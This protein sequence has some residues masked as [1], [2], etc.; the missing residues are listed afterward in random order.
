MKC[1][2]FLLFFL[3]FAKCACFRILGLNPFDGKSHFVMFER[4]YMELARR[5]HE[6]DVLSHFPREKPVP[7][8]TDISLKGSLPN[9]VGNFSFEL[10]KDT[11]TT[12]MMN[13]IT[14]MCGT[15]ICENAFKH[16]LTLKLKNT[17][18]KYDLIITEI[19]GTDCMFGFAHHF[20]VPVV[21][22]TTSVNQPWGNSRFGNPEEPTYIPSYFLPYTTNMSLV[23]KFWNIWNSFYTKIYYYKK[24]IEPSDY[25]VK[26]FFGED[27]PHLTELISRYSSL[28]MVNS[29][30]SINPARPWVPNVIEV[31]GLH[32][33]DPRPLTDSYK[34]VM[35]L[36]DKYKGVVYMSFGSL[37]MLQT[38]PLDGLKVL[39]S[40]FSLLSDYK[41]LVKGDKSKIP[42]SVIISPNVI[43]KSWTPQIDI[44]CHP[45]VVLFISHAGLMGTQESVFCGVPI[46]EMPFF[47]D[48]TLNAKNLVLKGSALE[49]SFIDMSKEEILNV[50][51]EL[52][53]NPKYRETAK[54]LSIQFKDR[55]LS[56]MDTAIYWIE[57]VIRHNGAKQLR[58]HASDMTFFEY[59]YIDIFLGIFLPFYI[60]KKL[61]ASKLKRR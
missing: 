27:T 59:Y 6:L 31:G 15:N 16:P 1:F 44:L 21:T 17:K 12:T 45:N 14:G 43:F 41:F 52:L 46:L 40:T 60:I 22:L 29:H 5:G 54:Q 13:I 26:Q 24:S 34:T 55:P 23:E 33:N 19:F 18:K 38:L 39:F 9:L 48:Q 25:Y 58:S 42:D 3:F 28:H 57:Y 8:Y 10:V 2:S 53:E 56:A 11:T 35:S 4:L 36:E 61:I 50:L 30:F 7:R 47:G 20:D 32:I 49:I 37:L 51:K